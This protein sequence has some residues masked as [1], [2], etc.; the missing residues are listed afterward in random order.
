MEINKR[1]LQFISTVAI[2]AFHYWYKLGNSQIERFIVSN[3]YIGVD[4]FFICSAYSL[5]RK[6]KIDYTPF[7]KNR[8][9]TIYLK[10]VFFSFI[11]SFFLVS[12]KKSVLL[13]K[14][15]R[16]ISIISGYE[17]FDKGGAAFL[18]FI[19]AI[20]IFYL[21]FPLF[22][23]W[24]NRNKSLY[25]L[26][27]YLMLAVLC[28]NA[29]YRDIF[30]VI[31]RI[32]LI[33]ITYELSVRKLN[34]P[35]YGAIILGICGIVSLYYFSYRMKLNTPFYDSYYLA[36]I[37]LC[38][39]VSYLSKYCKTYKWME[40]IGAASLEIYAL[41]MMFGYKL[42]LKVVKM[43][44]IPVLVNIMVFGLIIVAGI[45]LNKLFTKVL[46]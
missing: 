13:N 29:G 44:N 3:C 31:N 28:Q 10:Y 5:S 42:M 7:I 36:A 37:P 38:I 9:K 16:F 33:L 19:P 41:Q 35:L 1:F 11:Y 2:L 27:G 25:V 22:I 14:A 17:L 40:V 12:Y 18:W 4:L 21:L 39:C 23:N 20:M 24:N 34:M 32:P 45:I 6:K 8:F 26:V 15:L 43:C 46:K 30:I